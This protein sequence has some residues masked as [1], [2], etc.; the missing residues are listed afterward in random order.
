MYYI[1]VTESLMINTRLVSSNALCD[2]FV[3]IAMIPHKKQLF[4]SEFNNSLDLLRK[5]LVLTKAPSYDPISCLSGIIQKVAPI[6][7]CS[8]QRQGAKSILTPKAVDENKKIGIAVR[9][10]M[11][12]ADS[13]KGPLST[14]LSDEFRAVLDGSSS[15]LVKRTNVHKLALANR[16]NIVLRDRKIYRR[17]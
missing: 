1:C 17:H 2:R 15:T 13:R 14:R 6:V 12:A 9:W 8:S 7:I 5:H 10:I 11:T 4:L 3:R 16:S